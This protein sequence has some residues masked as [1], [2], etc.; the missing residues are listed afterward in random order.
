MEPAP[1]YVLNLH[2]KTT[3]YNHS[4]SGP[5]NWLDIQSPIV[6]AFE[7][8]DALVAPSVW[9]TVFEDVGLETAFILAALKNTTW[10]V[11]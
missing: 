3:V 2:N 6:K 9:R 10:M 4:S 8:F 11:D 5:A 1:E 7:L